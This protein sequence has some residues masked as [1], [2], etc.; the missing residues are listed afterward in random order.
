MQLQIYLSFKVYNLP[1]IVH[2]NSAIRPHKT[3]IEQ[4]KKTKIRIT[5]LEGKL[6]KVKYTINKGF[7]EVEDNAIRTRCQKQRTL[8][9]N[10]I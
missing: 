6:S 5:E 4:C 8:Q 10:A 9:Y 1:F 2:K 3:V 7:T